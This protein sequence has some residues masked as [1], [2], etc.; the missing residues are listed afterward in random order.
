MYYIKILK[1]DQ[2]NSDT[3]LIKNLSLDIKYTKIQT[4]PNLN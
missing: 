3:P 2:I 1:L 4:R